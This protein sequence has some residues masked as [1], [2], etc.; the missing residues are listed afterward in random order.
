MAMSQSTLLQEGE[1]DKVQQ[2]L[3]VERGSHSR[4]KSKVNS[5]KSTL[6]DESSSE[7]SSDTSS[8]T[9]SGSDGESESGDES[10]GE[11]VM[12]HSEK[13]DTRR[14]EVNKNSKNNIEMK[15]KQA[16]ISTDNTEISTDDKDSFFIEE[17][18]EGEDQSF[19]MGDDRRADSN[20]GGRY[21]H[22]RKPMRGNKRSSMDRGTRAT[23]TKQEARLLKWQKGVRGGRGGKPI[24]A[25]SARAPYQ[26]D[27]HRVSGK[28][29][30]ENENPQNSFKKPYHHASGSGN[31]SSYKSSNSDTSKLAWEVGGGVSSQNATAVTR[32][33]LTGSIVKVDTNASKKIIFD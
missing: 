20:A 14:R 22:V 31:K 15:I 33:K 32:Q 28:R 13:I 2:V 8:D 3:E 23:L 11:G 6:E 21:Q 27:D 16:Q 12:H 9:S 19:G 1:V 30:Y 10:E 26:N 7:S 24:S 25:P 4:K 18:V 29:K 17:C 5:T